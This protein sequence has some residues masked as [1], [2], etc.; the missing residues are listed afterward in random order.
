MEFNK[1]HLFGLTILLYF[2][3]LSVG[4]GF[5]NTLQNTDHKVYKDAT[6]VE[7]WLLKLKTY[8]CS[9]L[10]LVKCTDENVYLKYVQ[11]MIYPQRTKPL[12]IWKNKHPNLKKLYQTTLHSLNANVFIIPSVVLW[13]EKIKD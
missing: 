9:L 1:I 5:W 7:R 11:N 10:F 12:E 2:L 13:I 4:N 3:N 6:K 8:K